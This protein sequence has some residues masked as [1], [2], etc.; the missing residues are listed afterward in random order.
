MFLITTKFHKILLSGFRGVALT[1]KP[2]TDEL[3]KNIKPFTTCCMGYK[4][5]QLRF[6]CLLKLKRHLIFISTQVEQSAYRD[7][8]VGQVV[9]TLGTH[10]G[11]LRELEAA[12]GTGRQGL[13]F[14][15]LIRLPHDHLDLLLVLQ[16]NVVPILRPHQHGC[17]AEGGILESRSVTFNDR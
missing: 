2:R 13:L 9:F 8:T 1:N 6:L 4:N 14:L 11:G 5:K 10:E 12:V 15:G 3:V 17:I 7:D 16:V